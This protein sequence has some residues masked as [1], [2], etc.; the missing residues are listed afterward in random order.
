MSIASSYN[1]CNRYHSPGHAPGN[2]RRGP[3]KRP[4][5][6]SDRSIDGSFAV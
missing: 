6:R 2:R 5:C 1:R 4:V 3:E